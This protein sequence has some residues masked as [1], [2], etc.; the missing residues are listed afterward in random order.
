M[1]LTAPK[2]VTLVNQTSAIDWQTAVRQDNV[3]SIALRRLIMSNFL[4]ISA[5]SQSNSYLI[6]LTR[7]LGPLQDK[8]HLKLKLGIDFIQFIPGL[9]SG[10][11]RNRFK[12]ITILILVLVFCQK[13]STNRSASLTMF[14]QKRNCYEGMIL[15]FF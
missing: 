3:I 12:I 6:L 2:E 13:D 14:Q 5:I 10:L 1:W 8:L 11:F 9:I 4:I 15:H 7:L